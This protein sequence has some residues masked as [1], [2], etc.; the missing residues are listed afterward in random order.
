MCGKGM[1]DVAT[2]GEE[3]EEGAS[4]EFEDMFEREDGDPKEEESNSEKAIGY[5]SEELQA[6]RDKIVRTGPFSFESIPVFMGHGTED[7]KV[8]IE[9]GRLAADFLDIIGVNIEWKEYEGLGH[10]YSSDMLRD[11][12]RFLKG[13]DGWKDSTD[14]SR[15]V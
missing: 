2:G 6:E 9:I 12:V 8:P 7:E 10:W 4:T 14:E 3:Q 13:L 5:L 15:T 1:S 11:V